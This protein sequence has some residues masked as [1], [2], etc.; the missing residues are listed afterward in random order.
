MEM[1]DNENRDMEVLSKSEAEGRKNQ[2]DV[3]DFLVEHYGN[4]YTTSYIEEQLGIE[5]SDSYGFNNPDVF[6]WEVYS[7]KSEYRYGNRYYYAEF[8]KEKAMFFVL[9]AVSVVVTSL[10]IVGY[11]VGFFPLR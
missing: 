1:E 7:V 5:D 11:Y 3:R 10:I 4:A 2:K 8:S 9:F 6:S